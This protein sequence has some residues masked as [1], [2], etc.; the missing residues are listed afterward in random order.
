MARLV[1]LLIADDS[2]STRQLIKDFFVEKTSAVS[3]CA[4][5]AQAL[6]AYERIHADWVLMDIQ[7]PVMGGLEAT[8]RI[9]AA[10]PQARIIVVTEFAD[11]EL[12][13]EARQA[14]ACGYVLKDD[15]SQLPQIMAGANRSN[16]DFG[17]STRM[18]T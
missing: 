10:D 1:K 2:A 15:L 7:M 12:R 6:A 11:A 8:R 9:K 5:G 13:A 18:N 14:G 3:E 4:D 17:Q 16:P